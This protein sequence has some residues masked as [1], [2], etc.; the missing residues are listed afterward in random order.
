MVKTPKNNNTS[1]GPPTVID[2]LE[3]FREAAKGSLGHKAKI[4]KKLGCHWETVNRYMK[5]YPEET[6]EIIK[7]EKEV[8]VNLAEE[9]AR[10]LLEKREVQMTKFVLSTLGREFGYGEKLEIE[11]K[12]NV[13]FAD[14]I[15]TAHKRRVVNEEPD[16]IE[17]GE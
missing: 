17:N 13:D 2:S 12:V 14:A 16:L 11:G 6:A 8:L 5:K 7:K 10:D 15:A 1:M 4:A 9:S 3:H